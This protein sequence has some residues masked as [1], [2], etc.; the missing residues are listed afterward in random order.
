M[1]FIYPLQKLWFMMLHGEIIGD[2]TDMT[3]EVMRY[4]SI[5]NFTVVRRSVGAKEEAE[6]FIMKFACI[7]PPTYALYS[8]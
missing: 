3:E 6:L 5:Y 8:H 1:T 7:F 2:M 4:I